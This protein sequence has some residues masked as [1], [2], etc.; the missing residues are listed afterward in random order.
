MELIVPKIYVKWKYVL[1]IT[2]N[3]RKHELLPLWPMGPLD[4]PS[5]AEGPALETLF[6]QQIQ[7]LNSSLNLGYT[8][9]YWRTSNDTEVDFVLYGD[10][11]LL[12]FEIKRA[13][14]VQ[15]QALRG[16]KA[17][18]LDYPMSKAYF[19]YGGARRMYQEG[20]EIIPLDAALRE[21][22]SLLEIR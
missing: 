20:I 4:S 17:F 9:Y 16:L 22:P 8:I 3:T 11:G 5:E 18:L 6:F 19:I 21:L 1:Q 13:G 12:A 2:Q 14:T 15:S 10:R 7:A